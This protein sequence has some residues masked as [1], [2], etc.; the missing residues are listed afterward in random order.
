MTTTPEEVAE[1]ERTARAQLGKEYEIGLMSYESKITATG[2][3]PTGDN[4]D[5]KEEA[6]RDELERLINLEGNKWVAKTFVAAEQ[7]GSF[8]VVAT[9]A[10]VALAALF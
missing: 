9:G 1:I 3:A 7:D 4:L 8:A 5:P 10:F 2:V 6:A